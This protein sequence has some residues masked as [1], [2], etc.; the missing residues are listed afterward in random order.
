MNR[1]LETSGLSQLRNASENTGLDQERFGDSNQEA[2]E[3]TVHLNVPLVGRAPNSE[4]VSNLNLATSCLSNDFVSETPRFSNKEETMQ[5]HGLFKC[6]EV[7]NNN[8]IEP[9]IIN[10]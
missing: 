4:Y 8:C 1:H 6:N 3:N 9:N 10:D 7:S 5:E 2:L